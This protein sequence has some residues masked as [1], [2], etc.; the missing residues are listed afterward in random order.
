MDKKKFVKH[1]VIALLILTVPFFLL[2]LR[3]QQSDWE[4]MS[5]AL[6]K[7]MY[8]NLVFIAFAFATAYEKL[9]ERKKGKKK[10]SG[11]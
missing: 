3:L 8:M 9:Q 6:R 10:K 2:V 4:T 7:S 5:S 11:E 1:R